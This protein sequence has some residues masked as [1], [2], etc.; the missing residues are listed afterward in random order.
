MPLPPRP[1]HG[2]RVARDQTDILPLLR[3]LPEGTAVA[4]HAAYAS[5]LP[6]RM[7]CTIPAQI[8][9]AVQGYRLDSK[10]FPFD[11]GWRVAAKLISL[12][13]LWNVVRV[14]GGAYG[15]GISVQRGGSI[16]SYSFRDPSPAR[17]LGVN[18]SIPEFLRDF[19]KS[20]EPL[21][22]YIISAISDEEPLRTPRVAG[23]IADT[24]WFYGRTKD[25]LVTERRQMLAV[26][27]ESL[28][29]SCRVWDAF[30]SEGAVCVCAS[31]DLLA[32]CEDLTITE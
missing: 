25:E 27:R 7:G 13:Y 11:A 22:K 15:T 20:G 8:G 31:E 1:R 30:A 28:L 24:F 19:C 23:S 2:A 32:A 14:Q 3:A 18:A 17:S 5:S 9:F 10:R 29:D 4:E 6:E 12:S 16:Y 26:T 21:D